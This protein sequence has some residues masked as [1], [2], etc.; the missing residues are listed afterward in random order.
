MMGRTAIMLF[1]GYITAYFTDYRFSF[2]CS[3]VGALGGAMLV[4]CF[5]WNN[6]A[7][8]FLLRLGYICIGIAIAYIANRLICPFKRNTAIEYLCKRYST[9][10]ELLSNSSLDKLSDPQLYY[11]LMVHTLLQEEK[12]KDSIDSTV[13]NEMKA[14]SIHR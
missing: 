6:V 9:T 14:A 4:D 10:K 12:I 11:N 3:T 2:A 5:G 7:G 8:M 1:F 13:W